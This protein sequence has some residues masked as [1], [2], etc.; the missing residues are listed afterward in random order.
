[1]ETIAAVIVDGKTR[2]KQARNRRKLKTNT[3]GVT[4][5]R[6]CKNKES[7]I[8]HWRSI[9]GK[10][11]SKSFSINKYGF[12]VAFNL[13]CEVRINAIEKLNNQGAGYSLKH[14]L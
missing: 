1:M 11:L 14:G 5:V 12:E 10:S 7:W 4:G 13:A 9:D 6:F 8:A 2:K 3:S